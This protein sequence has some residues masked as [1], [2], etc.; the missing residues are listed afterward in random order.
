[1]IVIKLG[2]AALKNSLGSPELF[3]I[4]AQIK[5]PLLIVHGGGPEINALSLKLG[6]EG[7][8]HDGQR[9]TDAQHLEAV[10]M[11]LSG[12]VNSTL[13]RSSLKA[14]LN[15]VGVSGCDA[16]LLRCEPEAKELGLVGHVTKVNVHFLHLLLNNHY[17]PVVSP[18]GFFNGYLPCNVNADLA[19]SA[20]AQQLGATK[21]LFLTDRDGILDS[22]GQAM[23]TL[24]RSHLEGL[25]KNGDS[26]S[27]GMKVKARAILETLDILPKCE[28]SVMNGTDWQALTESLLQ[29]KA[30]GTQIR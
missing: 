9:V 15:A 29:G 13:V 16:G 1:M 19:A 8:F 6:F 23:A 10:E 17:V 22:Q 14:G 3:E 27:G 11:V 28:I 12:K 18:V 24:T 21:L 2:G 25:L 4:L 7:K 30:V 20:L 26:I 5:E